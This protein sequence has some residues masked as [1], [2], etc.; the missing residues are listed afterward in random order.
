[1][2]AIFSRY[3]ST[4]SNNG[5]GIGIFWDFFD[6]KVPRY[7]Y[8]APQPEYMHGELDIDQD[9]VPHWDDLDEREAYIEAQYILVKMF[10]E[11]FPYL[12]QVGNGPMSYFDE[13]FAALLDGCN[14]EGAGLFGFPEEV[15]NLLDPE[16]EHNLWHIETLYRT[17]G[18]GPLVLVDSIR[19]PDY[20]EPIARMGDHVYAACSPVRA[21]RY[22]EPD[23]VYVGLG[24][25]LGP[26][27]CEG[28]EVVRHF[29]NG[30]LLLY[31]TNGGRYPYPFG[32]KIGEL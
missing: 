7:L 24:A 2:L 20:V 25:P 19:F 15:K 14:I 3:Y 6:F 4:S 28:D 30:S 26:A 11:A 31:L 1:M 13:D 5:P 18:G 10:R 27:T 23:P 17:E 9:G 29:E 16:H 8:G 32:M 21:R 22:V 12:L